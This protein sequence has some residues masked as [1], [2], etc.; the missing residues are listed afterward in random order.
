MVDTS[1]AAL[2]PLKPCPDAADYSVAGPS[3]PTIVHARRD[4]THA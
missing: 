1:S 2:E 4:F 3:M